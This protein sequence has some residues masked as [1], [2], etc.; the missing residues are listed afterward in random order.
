MPRERLTITVDEFNALIAARDT[1]FAE[2][3]ALLDERATW[4]AERDEL[5]G[6]AR[7]GG[8]RTRQS[9]AAQVGILAVRW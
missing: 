8:D 2:R 4:S 6:L 5:R 7:T 9:T 1:A 3:D